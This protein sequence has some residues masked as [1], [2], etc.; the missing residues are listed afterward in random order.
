MRV[1][2]HTTPVSTVESRSKNHMPAPAGAAVA[3]WQTCTSL[4][5]P[6][7]FK[8][9]PLEATN[10]RSLKATP[11]ANCVIKVNGTG[12]AYETRRCSTWPPSLRCSQCITLQCRGCHHAA[13]PSLAM[14]AE[15]LLK[16]IA[17]AHR[18]QEVWVQKRVHQVHRPQA[19]FL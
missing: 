17:F 19:N 16:V 7:W 12:E 3:Y 5:Q 10:G 2:R 15:L 8:D 11:T 1:L 6:T 14:T 13:T 9:T 4:L 18:R